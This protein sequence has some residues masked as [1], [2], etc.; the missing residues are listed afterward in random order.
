MEGIR[1][2]PVARPL[3]RAPVRVGLI[4]CSLIGLSMVVGLDASRVAGVSSTAAPAAGTLLLFGGILLAVFAG[5]W[6][7]RS[8]IPGN[9]PDVLDALT[10]LYK[11][12]YADR[13][14][15][16]RLEENRVDA[17]LR[18]ALVVMQLDPMD[19][20]EAR[21]GRAAVNELLRLLGAQI[22]G[23]VR[24][25]DL[26]VRYTSRRLGV[27]LYCREIEQAQAFGRRIAMLSA[28]Q[29]L[30]W[31]G[32]IIKVTVAMGIALH[33]PDETLA[34]LGVCAEAKLTEMGD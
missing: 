10:G 31:Q 28:A 2:K 11:R 9:D 24:S 17:P 33:M 3:N 26:A 23:Q 27:Y 1:L 13:M 16:A 7:W 8:R 22:Q 32:D 14:V 18:V 29:Q 5:V 15:Q 21:Y 30:D 34:H 19:R 4:G 25:G 12:D 6:L 20:I